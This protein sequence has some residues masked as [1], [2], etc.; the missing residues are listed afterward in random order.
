MK[1]DISIELLYKLEYFKCVGVIFDRQNE[2]KL[3][4]RNLPE[5]E[6]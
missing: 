2:S 5:Q 3:F 6:G 4:L 1:K